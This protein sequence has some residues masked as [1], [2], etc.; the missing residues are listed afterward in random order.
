MHAHPGLQSIHLM[1]A[2]P[3]HAPSAHAHSKTLAD[4]LIT[5]TFATIL[6]LPGSGELTLLVSMLAGLFVWIKNPASARQFIQVHALWLPS[7]AVASLPLMKGLSWIWSIDPVLTLNDMATHLHFLM[8]LPLVLLYRQ[9]H[10]PL[11]AMLFGTRI[12]A[13]LLLAWSIANWWQY[14]LSISIEGRLEAGAQN[15]GVL[16]QLVGIMALWWTLAYWRTPSWR[17]LATALALLAAVYAAGGRSHIAVAGA[18]IA[19]LFAVRVLF[20]TK[21]RWLRV[22]SVSVLL[23]GSTLLVGGMWAPI[24]QA[25]H[26]M[27]SYRQNAT[28]SG[29]AQPNGDPSAA[30]GTSVGNRA[31][32]YHVALTAFPDS[33]W[34]GFGGGTTKKVVSLYSPMST[35]FAATRH[36]HQQYLQVL[37][38]TGIAGLLMASTALLALTLWLRARSRQDFLLWACYLALLYSTAAVG[39]LTGVL[40]QGL[41]HAFLVMAL[42]VMGAQACIPGASDRLSPP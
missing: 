35:H 1:H 10:N 7:L 31:G 27:D 37:M 16:G 42:A 3:N 14:G 32:L 12:A 19:T 23:G 8:W 17:A 6:V 24:Q 15:A 18:G 30:V 34:L 41:I 29:A 33:P 28:E 5:W 22:L 13:V 26:E 21:G 25:A 39:M 36:Y 9:A 40:Q 38:D 11:D 2:E 4:Y 20:Q